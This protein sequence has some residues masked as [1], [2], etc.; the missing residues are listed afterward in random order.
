MQTPL[1][2]T[3]ALLK[4]NNI[5]ALLI[6][7]VADLRWL[8]GAQSTFDEEAAHVG[9]ITPKTAHIHTDSRYYQALVDHCPYPDEFTFDKERATVEAWTAARVAELPDSARCALQDS[10]PIS[11]LRAL[12]EALA[13]KPA[14]V[15]LGE[16]MRN[17]RA[18]K[19]SQEI[20]YLQEAQ[21]ITDKALLY[22]G[23][24]IHPSMT[25]KAIRAELDNFMLQNGADAISFE[26]IIAAGPNGANP[27][28]R[29]GEYQ[30]QAGDLI[31]IDFGASKYDYH[32]DMTRT[33][34]LGEPSSEQRAVYEVVREA[35]ETAAAALKPGVIGRDIHAIA[36]RVIA[37]AGYGD[38]FE[39]GLGHGVGIE[40]HENPNLSPRWDKPIPKHSVVTVEPGIYLPYKFGIRLED[41]GVVTDDGFKPF[42]RINHDLRVI[43]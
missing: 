13:G 19:T 24:N 1:E 28:A 8:T 3:R 36:Q 43:G 29:A 15:F 6:T 5:D 35:H 4:D 16:E 21:D 38:Y 27:H 17:L 25:E 2:R 10:A 7:D 32:A 23:D 37:D 31:V 18:I 39:H 33:F 34:S 11:F 42:T 9:L 30:V 26:T 22:I 41:T 20:A 14:P 40:I 12:D